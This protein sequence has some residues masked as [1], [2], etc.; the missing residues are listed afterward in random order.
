M[1]SLT[2]KMLSGVKNLAMQSH[3]LLPRPSV[4]PRFSSSDSIYA[5]QAYRL[6]ADE[7]I[8]RL[9]RIE[10]QLTE[11]TR[12]GLVKEGNSPSRLGSILQ[13]LPA[14]EME[15]ERLLGSMS[16]DEVKTQLM[17]EGIE[18]QWPKPLAAMAWPP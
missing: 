2:R 16:S 15:A 13:G 14:A 1:I 5:Y 4:V 10:G 18:K 11:L 8:I 12:A 3:E 6:E 7:V 9:Q 17:R